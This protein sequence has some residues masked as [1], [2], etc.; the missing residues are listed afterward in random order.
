MARAGAS[1]AEGSAGSSAVKV[2]GGAVAQPANTPKAISVMRYRF[3]VSLP[4]PKERVWFLPLHQSS[5]SSFSFSV[6]SREETDS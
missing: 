2:G 3:M 5:S 4:S 1:G 6:A